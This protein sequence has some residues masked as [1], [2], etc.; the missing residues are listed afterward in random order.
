[1]RD[2]FVRGLMAL[3]HAHDDVFLITGDLG[4]GV[5]NTFQDTFPK[6]YLN[7]GISEQAMLGMAAGMAL[8]GR[9]VFVYSIGNFPTLR[10][11]EQ[12]RNDCAYHNANVKIISVGGGFV[13]GALGMSHHATE[14]VAVMR[15]LPDVTVFSPGDPHEVMALLPIMYETPGTCYMRLGRGNEPFAHAMPLKNYVFP[16]GIELISGTE[17]AVLSS[18]GILIQCRKAV[19]GLRAEGHDIGL[20]SFPVV[21]PLDSALIAKIAGEQPFIV[22]VEEHSIVGGFGGAVSEIVAQMKGA[23]AQVVRL[24]LEDCYSGVV[25][26]QQYLRGQYGFDSKHIFDR[27]K[28]LRERSHG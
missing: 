1:M 10:A 9:T 25:G 17:G 6:Q 28:A 27:V 24:G 3:A 14:D 4:F 5:L 23:R 7:A 22:T 8:E 13:Y 15:A 21:K 2:A 16:R 12:I 20:Y 11:L 26:S 19:M 18:G